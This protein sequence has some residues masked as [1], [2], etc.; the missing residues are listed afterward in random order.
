MMT[1]TVPESPADFA[2]QYLGDMQLGLV[3]VNLG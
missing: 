2:I 3:Q 1:E